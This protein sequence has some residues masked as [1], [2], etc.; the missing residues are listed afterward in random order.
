ML[1]E[2]EK[3]KVPNNVFMDWIYGNDIYAIYDPQEEQVYLGF[4]DIMTALDYKSMYS[5]KKRVPKE[6]L[7]R[8]C[9]FDNMPIIIGDPKM[10]LVNA[11]GFHEIYSRS[12]KANAA[13]LKERN[14]IVTS[15]VFNYNYYGE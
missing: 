2:E 13:D 7:K 4:A 9:D 12:R 3:L 11:N 1:N 6:C 15:R 14:K 10:L 5:V 8:L